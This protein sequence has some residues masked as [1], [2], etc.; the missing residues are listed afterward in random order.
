VTEAGAPLTAAVVTV[1]TE[2]VTGVAVDTN[3]SEIALA[4]ARAGIDVVEAVSVRDEEERLASTVRRLVDEHEIV[5]VT[6]GLGPTHDDITREAVSSALGLPLERDAS[7][8]PALAAW[9]VRHSDPRARDQL[10]SQADVLR[11]A[12]VLPPVLG[13]APGQIIAT[14]RGMLVLLPGPP[15][16]MRPMLETVSR[17]LAGS[18]APPVVLRC[19]GITESD[20]Q[21]RVLDVVEGRADVGF[22]VLAA[23]GDVRAVLFDRGI[24]RSSLSALADR[25]ADHLGDVCY[26]RDGAS[27]AEVVLRL[28]RA[29]GERLATAESCTGGLVASALTAVPGASDTFVGSVVAYAN[30]A[31]MALLGVDAGMLAQYGSVSDEVARAMAEG[32][33]GA[34]AADRAVAVTGVAGPD[35]GSDERPVGTVWFG[36]AGPDGIRAESRHLPGDREGVRRRAVAV[37]LD[38]LRRS[39]GAG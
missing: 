22:T 2:L 39:Y 38:I 35:G 37:A 3:T 33:R 17:E 20:A 14:A 28:A 31:K 32:A 4:L 19:A 25:V 24:G 21:V 6:G 36:L 1:G 8:E 34:L 11:G 15:H 10:F 29:R 23:P 7:L 30:E 9:T 27:L 16:E 5:V 13:T 18:S 26:S 12:R